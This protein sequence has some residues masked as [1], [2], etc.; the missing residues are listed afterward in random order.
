MTSFSLLRVPYVAQ[1]EI[2]C[3]MTPFDLYFLS[4]SSK[5]AKRLVRHS[6][7]KKFGIDLIING[8]EKAGQLIIKHGNITY[9]FVVVSTQRYVDP[10]MFQI[11]EKDGDYYYLTF[12]DDVP[13]Q[14]K[15]LMNYFHEV[16]EMKLSTVAL[17]VLNKQ[18]LK[19]IIDMITS[20]QPEIQDLKLQDI[21]GPG[22]DVT[23][24]LKKVRT[25]NKL[26]IDLKLKSGIEEWGVLLNVNRGITLTNANGVTAK[27]GFNCGNNSMF[28]LYVSD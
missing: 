9:N 25:V 13:T 8:K 16:F 17:A 22:L 4:Q 27:L 3:N 1:R 26:W 5:R 6:P 23:E 28:F 21:E 2:L 7:M 18:T 14:M 10:G 11:D 19:S 20:R 24:L 12:F 15:V